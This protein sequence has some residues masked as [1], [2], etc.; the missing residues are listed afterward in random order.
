MLDYLYP[1]TIDKLSSKF[2]GEI[3]I[4]KSRG[5]YTVWIGG[6]EQSGGVY[7]E[8]LWKKAL[9]GDHFHRAAFS[10][11]IVPATVRVW[12]ATF[13]STGKKGK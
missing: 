1:Q 4:S 13:T 8:G 2:N 3:K 11:L 6:F 9:K 5:K 12:K 10:D 7:V